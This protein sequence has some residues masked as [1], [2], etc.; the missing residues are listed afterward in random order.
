MI[1]KYEYEYNFGDASAAIEID[2]EKL[3]QDDAKELLAFFT[4]DYDKKA[5]P[6]DEIGRLYCR[7][8]MNF[9]TANSHNTF[10][11]K[12]D[13]KEAEGFPEVDGTY[14]ITL[15]D[16]HGIDLSELEIEKVE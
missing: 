9:A 15:L 12:L 1:K 8:A 7:Q 5:D 13:F 6:Y 2:T 11:V 4:W 16:V 3:T 10:G 14:G